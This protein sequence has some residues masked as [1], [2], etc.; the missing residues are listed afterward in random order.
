M[1]TELKVQKTEKRFLQKIAKV[2]GILS[3]IISVC[4]GIYLY[5]IVGSDDKVLKASM[6]AITFFFFTVALVL[7]TMASADLP[8]L[9]IDKDKQ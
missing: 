8:N 2:I 6:G 3:A 4:C 1:D 9:K 5:T 7:N